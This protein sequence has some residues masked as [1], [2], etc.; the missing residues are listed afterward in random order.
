M[1]TGGDPDAVTIRPV[2]RAD[3]LDVVG[4]ERASFQEPWPYAAFER[5]LGEPGFLVAVREG[6]VVGFVVSDV[7]P[8][9]GRDI[10]HVKDIAI[11]SNARGV[12]IGRRLLARALARLATGG[13]TLVKLEVRATNEP[14]LSLYRSIG[15]EPIRR[16]PRY[17]ED[18]ED[19]LVMVLDVDDWQARRRDRA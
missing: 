8:N 2:E 11:R 4:I 19:A 18:G 5:F 13:A 14:A 1:N 6:M 12:G 15:F 9:H 7:T 3:L 10:G 17:Y 16:V